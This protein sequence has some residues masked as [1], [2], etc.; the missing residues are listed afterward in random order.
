MW[1]SPLPT[2]TSRIHLQIEQFSQSTCWT[3]A[4]DLGHLKGQEKSPRKRVGLKKEKK[5]RKQDGT[6]TPA[7][8]LKERRGYRTQGSPLTSGESSWDR[9]GASGARRRGQ[10]SVC[11]RQDRVRPTR[12][13]QMVRAAALSAPDR[14]LCLLGQSGA[15]C[16]NMGSGEWTQG[17]DSCWLWRDSLKGRE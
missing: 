6:C 2:S 13:V 11:G 17:G 8:E 12:M 16:W 10:Q 15:A 3:L 7:G 5:K 9:E 4:E 14:V 1:S